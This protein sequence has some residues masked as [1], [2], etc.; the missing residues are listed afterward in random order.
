MVVADM[1]VITVMLRGLC[2]RINVGGDI[3]GQGFAAGVVQIVCGF[4]AM[5]PVR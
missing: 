1:L 4:V 3:C 5:L 2:E